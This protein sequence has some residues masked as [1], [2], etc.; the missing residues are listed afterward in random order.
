MIEV[1]DG[2]SGRKLSDFAGMTEA[3]VSA[4]LTE[5]VLRKAAK[6]ES[7]KL[8]GWLQ[9]SKLEVV[10]GPVGDR[11]VG[12]LRDD[13]G[14]IFAGVW[15]RCADLKRSAEESLKS[16]E[17]STVVLTDHEFSYEVEPEVDVYVNNVQFGAFK[18][19][20][21]VLCTVEAMALQ[22]EKGCVT[23]IRSGSCSGGAEISLAGQEVWKRE[24]VREDLPGE[25]RMTKPVRLA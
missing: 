10:S 9:A 7:E 2:E 8:T 1:R 23:A 19:V 25:L 11:L 3:A 22:L 14:G 17:A 4:G 16:A 15:R 21:K 20:V 6:N 13:M 12:M 24:F 5:E 18:F